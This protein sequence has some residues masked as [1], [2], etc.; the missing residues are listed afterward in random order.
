MSRSSEFH[1]ARQE[2]LGIPGISPF[3]QRDSSPPSTVPD[4]PA[5]SP[6]HPNQ[7]RMPGLPTEAPVLASHQ[8]DPVP[9]R[10]TP[11]GPSS[12]AAPVGGTAS[13]TSPR[14]PAVTIGRGGVATPTSGKVPTM[15]EINSIEDPRERHAARQVFISSPGIPG[16]EQHRKEK[17]AAVTASIMHA[18]ADL[19]EGGINRPGKQM[20]P[21]SRTVSGSR[22]YYTYSDENNQQ[23]DYDVHAAMAK[24]KKHV[25]MAKGL[26]EATVDEHGNVHPGRMEEAT[27][28]LLRQIAGGRAR[29]RNAQRPGQYAGVSGDTMAERAD[30]QAGADRKATQLNPVQDIVDFDALPETQRRN[31]AEAAVTAQASDRQSQLEAHRHAT[32]ERL[33]REIAHPGFIKS[34]GS[35]SHPDYPD[36]TQHPAY[37]KIMAKRTSTAQQLTESGALS[38]L[39]SHSLIVDAIK[40]H[41][42]PPVTLDK[43]SGGV[44]KSAGGEV[45]GRGG[46]RY[47]TR[48]GDK[49]DGHAVARKLLASPAFQA[50]LKQKNVEQRAAGVRSAAAANARPTVPNEPRPAPP[51]DEARKALAHNL[52]QREYIDTGRTNDEG[53]RQTVIPRGKGEIPR[54]F[55]TSKPGAVTNAGDIPMVPTSTGGRPNRKPR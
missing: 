42:L 55:D 50:D 24:L 23:R 48:D 37:D 36:P 11:S 1:G 21:S 41:V 38:N 2:Q 27:R 19:H 6:V 32:A 3:P 15:A 10:V 35:Y 33:A 53:N 29:Q 4:V 16:D 20:R 34:L 46:Q 14:T 44:R 26:A 54:E 9:V 47:R 45:R 30:A 49:I 17:V 43:T 31:K 7:L 13:T 5:S 52:K 25:G 28:A 39:P 18:A 8:T 22:T 40:R 51:Q 12:L